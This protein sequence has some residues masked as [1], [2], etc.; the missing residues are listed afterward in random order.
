MA[1]KSGVSKELL[2]D[3]DER[4]TKSFLYSLSLGSYSNHGNFISNN[5]T[6]P[7]TDKIFLIQTDTIKALAK[8]SC[9]MVGRCADSILDNNN[10]FSVFIYADIDSRIERVSKMLN[11]SKTE[12]SG[13]IKKMDKKRA[14]YYNYYSDSRWGDALTYNLCINSN[15][16][17]EYAAELIVSAI[18]LR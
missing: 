9:V 10:V 18:K 8:T 6:L 15:C 1:K 17:I 4:P 5:S 2:E 7:L 12:A 14:S 3:Y 11:I 16:D 13:L